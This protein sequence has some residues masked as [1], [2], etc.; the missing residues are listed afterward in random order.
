M[1]GGTILYWPHSLF[2]YRRHSASVSMNPDRYILRVQ[3]E[4]HVYNSL[5]KS[6]LDRGQI[7][8]AFLARI[9]LTSRLNLTLKFLSAKQ[10]NKK[11]LFRLMKSF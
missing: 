5:A 3:E 6:L 7:F 1:S 4:I 10:N 11:Q 8:D 9:R 2:F